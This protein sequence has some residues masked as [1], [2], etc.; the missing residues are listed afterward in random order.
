LTRVDSDLV[1]MYRPDVSVKDTAHPRKVFS[2]EEAAH[3]GLVT[4]S[5]GPVKGSGT[6]TSSEDEAQLLERHKVEIRNLERGQQQEIFQTQ[7]QYDLELAKTR[8]TAEKVQI[9]KDRD[10]TVTELTSHHQV[11]IASRKKIQADEITGAKVKQGEKKK[12]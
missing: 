3:R 8:S 1:I 9:Q 7:K 5:G 10:R 12:K 11:E 6:T 4:R 2:E